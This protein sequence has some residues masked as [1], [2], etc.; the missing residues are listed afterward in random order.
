MLE[1][2]Q[3]AKLMWSIKKDAN[4]KF[5]RRAIDGDELGMV[6]IDVEWTHVEGFPEDTVMVPTTHPPQIQYKEKTVGR[7]KVI[8]DQVSV[9]SRVTDSTVAAMLDE[10]RIRLAESLGINP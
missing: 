1:Q 4:G 7:R 9:M 5:L 8:L 6:H 3:I 2:V 10:K